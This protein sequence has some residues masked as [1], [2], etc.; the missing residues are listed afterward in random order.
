MSKIR[1]QNLIRKAIQYAIEHDCR[2]VTI[3]HK[4]NIMKFTEGAF[5]QW[6]Y[7]LAKAEF[8]ELIVSEEENAGSSASS[9]KIILNDRI[10]DS[11]FQQ[12]LLRPR[13][14]EVLA[15]PN[16]NGDYLSDAAAAQVGGL[17]LAPGANLGDGYAVFEATHGSAPKHAGLDEANPGSLLLSA[18]M[19]LNF[20]GWTESAA[21]ISAALERTI[22]QKC[23][24]YDLARLMGDIR[25]VST[26]LFAKQIIANMS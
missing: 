1:S 16:L 26:S 22:L 23:V 6:G 9:G 20:L 5:K 10:A 12:L 2:V 11:M 13:E 18:V 8:S 15:A 3:V 7:E 17:G 14:Y 25:P 21:L 24:T 19:M 4:G